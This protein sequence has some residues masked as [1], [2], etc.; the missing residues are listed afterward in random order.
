MSKQ[1]L[2][3]TSTEIREVLRTC[4]PTLHLHQKNGLDYIRGRFPVT[5]NGVVIDNYLIEIEIPPDFPTSVPRVKEIGGRIPRIVDRHIFT[6]DCVCLFLPDERWKYWP[7]GSRFSE[8]MRGPVN[9]YFASQTYFEQNDRWPF[10]ER[11]H[12]QLGILDYYAEELGT[13][14][15]RVIQRCLELLALD[16]LRVD[17]PCYC[18]SSRPVR[19]CHLAKVIELRSKV[20]VE[21]ARNSLSYFARMR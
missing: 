19:N 17:L 12:A 15:L 4:Y 2:R 21:T 3:D 16:A 9:D 14:N 13:L 10:G 7:R 18:G 5:I 6:N 1:R 11:R 8:F 20:D